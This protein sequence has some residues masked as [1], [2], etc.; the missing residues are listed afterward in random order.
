MKTTISR[1]KP[2]KKHTKKQQRP[3]HHS[4]KLHEICD[5]VPTKQEQQTD[6]PAPF[7]LSR[8]LLYHTQKLKP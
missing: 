8:A 5:F 1:D 2:T 4:P 7:S 3:F 6:R